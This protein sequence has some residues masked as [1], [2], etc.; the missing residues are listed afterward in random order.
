MRKISLLLAI[1]FVAAMVS[2]C[3]TTSNKQ[4]MDSLSAKVQ[5]LEGTVQD[6]DRELSQLQG[7]IDQMSREIDDQ[8]RTIQAKEQ[9][10][11]AAPVE[12]KDRLGIIKV[13]VPATDIQS[14]L[15]EAGFYNGA[16]DGK[17][18]ANTISAIA[19]FQKANNLTSDS[20]VGQKTWDLLKTYLK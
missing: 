4:Q 15:K 2:G 1:V 18:G 20:I 12:T 14:A 8:K 11:M 13:N 9:A 10:R 6:R 5:T 3:Q 7:Q 17:V 16:I 19:A